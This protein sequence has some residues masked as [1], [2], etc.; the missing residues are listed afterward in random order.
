MITDLSQ[1]L[2]QEAELQFEA[3]NNQTAWNWAALLKAVLKRNR[4]T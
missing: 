3:F 1:L 4:L 2:A